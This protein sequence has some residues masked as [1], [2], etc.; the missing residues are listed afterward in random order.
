MSSTKYGR[1]SALVLGVLV[2]IFVI[3]TGLTGLLREAQ[4]HDPA[5]PVH[6][7]KVFF[8][9]FTYKSDGAFGDSYV[10]PADEKEDYARGSLEKHIDDWIAANQDVAVEQMT[11]SYDENMRLTVVTI[12][13]RQ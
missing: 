4:A 12:V 1:V 5:K 13:Y 2:A 10:V 9:S 3:G 7:A 6:H 8:G 11:Q